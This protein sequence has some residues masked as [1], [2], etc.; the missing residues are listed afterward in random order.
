MCHSSLSIQCPPEP[1]FLQDPKFRVF[2]IYGYL[3]GYNCVGPTWTNLSCW[4]VWITICICMSTLIPGLIFTLKQAIFDE[5]PKF[6][7]FFHYGYSLGYNCVCSTQT[8]LP[9][10]FLSS[11]VSA[12]LRLSLPLYIPSNKPLSMNTRNFGSLRIMAVC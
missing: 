11:F 6:R 1:I 12:C 2:L 3:R 7:V 10:I 8:K 4:E 5:D 9:G